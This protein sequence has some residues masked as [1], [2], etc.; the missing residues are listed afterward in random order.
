M[1]LDDLS[2]LPHI[3]DSPAVR[4]HINFPLPRSSPPCALHARRGWP[5]FRGT[6]TPPTAAVEP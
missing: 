1:F 4:D 6:F 2:E 3:E 5:T